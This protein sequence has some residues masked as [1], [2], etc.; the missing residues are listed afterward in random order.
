MIF[1]S[2]KNRPFELGPYPLERLKRDRLVLKIEG[3]R[4]K[5]S[6]RKKNDVK[7]Q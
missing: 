2:N 6:R 5:I 1:F 4:P 7:S 3:Q